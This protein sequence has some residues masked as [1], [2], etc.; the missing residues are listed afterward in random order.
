MKYQLAGILDDADAATI[1]LIEEE[2]LLLNRLIVLEE[3]ASH[4]LLNA[5]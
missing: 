3:A 4:T 1:G 2:R 5:P